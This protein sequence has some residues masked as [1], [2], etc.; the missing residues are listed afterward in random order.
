VLAT[1]RQQTQVAGNLRTAA[2][3]EAAAH[4]AVQQAIF[5]L[6][7]GSTGHWNADGVARTLR[8][9]TAIVEVRV[10]NEAD[11]VN[12]G[13]ASP[14]LLQALLQ[15]V[16]ADSVTASVVAGSIVEWRLGSG[17][18]GRRNATF[19]RY[20]GAGQGYA[21]SGEPIANVDEL[22][23]VIG[24]T[25]DL[26]ARLRPHLT[27]FTDGDPGANT[28]DPVVARALAAAGE[29]NVNASEIGEDVVS[30]T[31]DAR[32]PDHGRFTLHVVVRTNDRPEGRRYEI[33]AFEQL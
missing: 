26:L 19:Q 28:R 5:G 17:T 23:A 8:I 10:D 13:V 6:L 1:G 4:G 15:Q 24:M 25:P 29:F 7:D 16:G 11:K 33:L 12:P 20:Q 9:G 21:P 32:G 27:I 3:L 31:A 14:A 18:A 30:I 22:G 2:T